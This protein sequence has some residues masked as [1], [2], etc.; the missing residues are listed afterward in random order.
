[1]ILPCQRHLF[2]IPEDIAY[3][4]C[5][6]MSPLMRQVVSAGQQGVAS[7][8]RPWIITPADFF[9]DSN[10]AR[11]L[12]ARLIGSEAHN[13]AVIP[14]VSYGIATATANIALRAGQSIITL[15]DQFPSNVYAWQELARA[16]GAEMVTVREGNASLSESVLA[17]IDERTGV[18]ALAHCRWTDGALL[19]LPAIGRRC[20]EVGAALVLD[21]TQS[22]GAMPIDVAAIDADFLVAGC[23]KWMM[24]PYSLGF[25]H[26]APRWHQGKALEQTWLARA[27]SEN[28]AALVDYQ[29]DY[30]PGAQR[31]DM[32]ERSNFHLMPMAIAAMTQLLEWGVDNIADTLRATTRDIA[33]RAATLGLTSL[34][35][36]ARPAHY[37]GLRFAAGVPAGL[38]AQLAAENVFVSVRGQSVRVTPHVYNTPAD[39]ERL[40]HAL[41]LAVS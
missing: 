14:S 28:F 40:I 29:H 26:V 15:A 36:S 11:E 3:L 27:G 4:N 23:Y 39:S 19:D 41:T 35:E 34:D 7:K 38:P 16:S 37:L 1:M 13:I 17:Q 30:Q 12:F 10:H 24:G 21:I 32:G 33:T 5:A 31:F 9:T 25:M 8:A 22:V 6:Y 18:V 20:R 2:D